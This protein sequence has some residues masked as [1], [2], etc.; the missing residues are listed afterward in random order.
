[1]DISTACDYVLKSASKNN[2]GILEV[3]IEYKD[4]L[5]ERNYNQD[6]TKDE[7]TAFRMFMD[8][9]YKMFAPIE[10]AV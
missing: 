1:M 3:L 7:N 2:T 6:F 10:E 4:G 5:N 8:A 9:G